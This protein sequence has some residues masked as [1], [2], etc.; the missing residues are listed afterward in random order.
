MCCVL[1]AW[2]CNA[3]FGDGIRHIRLEWSGKPT[4]MFAGFVHNLM[5]YRQDRKMGLCNA[6]KEKEEIEQQ[7][8][9]CWEKEFAIC[10]CFLLLVT[11]QV[12]VIVW[13]CCLVWW[14]PTRPEWVSVGYERQLRAV[15]VSLPLL[16]SIRAL[17][18][19][20]KLNR[21]EGMSGEYGTDRP[22][23]KGK[24]LYSHDESLRGVLEIIWNKCPH[25][26]TFY[27][28]IQFKV[29]ALTAIAILM[30]STE[31]VRNRLPNGLGQILDIHNFYKAL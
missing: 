20:Q 29:V 28:R 7:F 10:F 31:S 27:T 21:K 6:R 16:H 13:E 22:W 24:L 2:K 17:H 9:S 26:K 23:K 11:N 19:L 5:G 18:F 3:S 14:E 15:L 1:L 4:E 12:F 8:I 30:P 25:G